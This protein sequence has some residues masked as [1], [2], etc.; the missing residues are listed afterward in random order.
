MIENYDCEQCEYFRLEG[1]E[2]VCDYFREVLE[3][4]PDSCP[5]FK[6]EK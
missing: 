5:A 4:V 2:G 6:K 1:I 3:Y